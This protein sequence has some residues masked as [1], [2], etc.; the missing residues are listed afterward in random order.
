MKKEALKEQTI[1]SRPIKALTMYP[2]K[3]PATLVPSMMRLSGKII[4]TANDNLIVDCLSKDVFYTGTDSVLTVSRFSD[5]HEALCAAQK[6]ASSDA[7]TF[8][9]VFVIKQL[10]DQIQ[11]RG[12]SKHMMGDRSQLRNFVKNFIGTVRFRND[13]FGAIMGYGDYVIG[14]SAISRVYYVEGLGH[15]LFSVRQFCDS[16]LEVSFRKHSCYVRDTD[17]VELIKGSRRSTLYTI[18]IEDMMKSSPIFLFFKASKNKSWLWHRRLN[19]LNFEAVATACYT[20]NRSLI[21]CHNKTPYELLHAKKP[22]LTILC[23]FGALCYPT[24][25]NEDLGKL[26]PTTDIGI[27][28]GLAPTFLTPGQISSGLVPDLVPAAPYVP[29]TNK[30]LEILFQ[31]MFD[32]YLKPLRVKR[33]VS[34]AL[35]VLVPVNSAGVAVESTIMEDNPFAH[36]EN[37]PFVNVFALE[38]R[39]K[40]SS[41]EDV[42]TRE[43]TYWI[44]KIK[45]DEY[46]DVLKNKARLV[47]KGYR[48]EEGIDFEESFAPV[49]HIKAIRILIA[50]AASKNMIIYQ[51]DVKTAF[52]NGELKEEVYVSQPEGF[53]DPNHP[54]HVYHLKKAF[55]ELKQAPRAWYDILSWFLLNNKFSKGAV[56]L[57][58][59]TQKTGKHILL[60]QIYVDDIIFASTDP[61]ACDIFFDE[62]SSKFEMS[63]M[64]QMSFFLCL[65]VSQNPGDIFIN[66]SEFALEILKKFGMD[67]C[68]PI[69]TP[70]VDRLKLNDDPLGILVNQTRF[71]SMVGSLMYLNASRPDLVFAIYMCA[72]YQA[73][74]T[75]KH[76][77]ALKWVFWYLKGTINWGLWCPKDTAMALMTYAD[78]DHAVT[79]LSAVIMSTTPG[80][81]TLTYDTISLENKMADENVPTLAPTRSDDQI[82]PFAAWVPIG[83]SNFV[84]DLHKRQKNPIF[85][86][87]VDILQNTNFFRAFTASTL[88][89]ET[90]FILDVNLRRDALE[91]MPIDQAHQFVS[92]P[93]GDAI[94]DLIC[95][96]VRAI[97]S[98]INQC[99]TSKTSGHDRPRYLVLQMLWGI[100]T[101]TNVDYAELLWEE[102]VQAIRT[103]LTDKA[104]LGSPTK[105]DR[106]DKPHF[107][108]YC[109][110]TKIIICHLG[111]I[112][113][114]HQRSAS[115]LHLVEEDFR[116]GNLKFVPKGK[117]DEVFGMPILDELISNNIRNAPYFNA[118]LEMVTKHDQKVAAKKPKVIK[119]RPSKA[120]NT[121]PPKPKPAKEKS[122]MTTLPEQVGKGKIVKV[123][124]AKSLFQLVDEPN[125]EPAHSE[126]EPEPELKHQGEGE[127]DDMECAIQMSLESFQA[128]SQAHVSGMA[129]RE[130]VAEAT[131]PLPVVEGKCKAIATEEQAAHSLLALHT[132][133][134]RNTTD[135]FVLQRRIPVTKVASTGPSAQAQDDTSV[136]I[137]RDSP[138]PADAETEIGVASEKT[139]CRD[140]TEILQINE[141]KGND[142]DDQVNLD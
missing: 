109:Q 122:T 135:Q 54:T 106:K 26:Q 57:T 30:D 108:A 107:I 128:Q 50:N 13:H 92:P 140:K 81:S 130:P 127:E 76:L 110:F 10:Q 18:S 138:S 9:L 19:H 124:K 112:H 93:S 139:N 87:S 91:I 100:I 31:Q 119:E 129:I 12:C 37:D 67:S 35:T 69:D 142:V 42:S 103:F 83:N 99:L 7:P 72:R 29:P 101:S 3:T 41:S 34:P 38:P 94:M 55:Y 62:T 4:L 120:S 113:N 58:L 79:S 75:K 90:R 77:E 80:P 47:A 95:K 52:L 88:L 32:E 45:L 48:Q 56:D 134:R 104:N 89:D 20:Q 39:S 14:D 46:G 82:L 43:S 53:V 59:F 125:E 23:V 86:I 97:I 1:A 33:P 136:N 131:R 27:F 98:M 21:T 102:F 121:K 126:S 78:A 17:G 49:A 2:P 68:D 133:K 22:D 8:E 115:L 66:Q 5:M 70:M 84:L 74:P 25:D 36:V 141:E 64:G 11:S 71:R 63:M 117:I 6:L 118:Y 111:R 65:Q 51:M 114:I 61:K 96:L 73:S 40:A 44:Y 15:N 85:Q 137:V 16:D 105:K 28:V 116:L 123:H 60:V 24:N 132:P